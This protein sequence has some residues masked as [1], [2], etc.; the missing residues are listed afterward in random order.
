MKNKR[1][2]TAGLR[3]GTTKKGRTSEPREK[4]SC[5]LS[6]RR[7]REKKMAASTDGPEKTISKKKTRGGEIRR[8]GLSICWMWNRKSD[9]KQFLNR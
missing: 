5:P 1:R 8:G 9:F 2:R 3:S 4:A 7:S 6:S